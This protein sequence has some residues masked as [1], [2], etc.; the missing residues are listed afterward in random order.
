MLK[1]EAYGL[2]GFY[3]TLAALLQFADFGLG[4]ALNRQ[5]ACLAGKD[6]SKREI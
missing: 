2:V 5:L 3:T 4:V 1:L 6:G